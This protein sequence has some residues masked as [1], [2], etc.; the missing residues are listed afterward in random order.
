MTMDGHAGRFLFFMGVLL[1]GWSVAADQLCAQS[2]PVNPTLKKKIRD[3]VDNLVVNVEL[4]NV[5]FTVTDRKGR[6]ITDLQRPNFKLYEDNKLQE[7]TNFSRETDLPLTIAVLIDTSTSITD[8]FKFEQE[9]AIE[10]LFQTLR[11]RKDKALL[12]TFDSA[13]ELVQDFTDDPQLLARSI[14]RIRPGGGTK[15]LDSIFLTC[16]EKLKAEPGSTRKIII[17]ISDGDDNLSIQNLASTL[18]MVHRSDVSIY[19]VSTNSSG[20]FSIKAPK[21]DKLLR[22]LARETG[23]RAFFPFKS[24]ELSESFA[25]IGTELRSQ[26]S[27][28]YR[29]SNTTR[30]GSFR[31]IKI[32]TDRKRL[33]VKSRKGYYASRSSS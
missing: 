31:S 11:P 25:N 28:A 33:K 18:E 32:R 2:L 26:Y 6:L 13:I 10:F 9:A 4:V 12:I 17:L 27:L 14:R 19:A 21:S 30:D 22:R 7:I 24:E 1:L 15:L 16:Q 8:R 23:G 29:S 3:D 20:F 5:L